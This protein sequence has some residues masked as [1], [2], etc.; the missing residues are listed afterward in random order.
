MGNK[1]Q[2]ITAGEKIIMVDIDPYYWKLKIVDEHETINRY[3]RMIGTWKQMIEKETNDENRQYF[4][5][6]QRV[7]EIEMEKSYERLEK[8]RAELTDHELRQR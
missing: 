4:E 2:A 8:Y 1:G 5:Y 3:A 7:D 6:F